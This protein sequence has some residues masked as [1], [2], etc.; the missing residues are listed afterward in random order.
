ME[1]DEQ[2]PLYEFY[3]Q[4]SAPVEL[5]KEHKDALCSPGW[6]YKPGKLELHRISCKRRLCE[7]CGQYWAYKW[8]KALEEKEKYG[9]FLRK[10]PPR[11]ALTLTTAQRVDFKTMWHCFRYFWQQIR[12]VYPKVKYF[13]TVEFNQ[14]H[15]QPHFHFIL[16]GYNFIDHEYIRACWE[17]AQVWCELENIAW[18]LR[19]ERIR[20]N[21]VAYF[22]KYITKMRGGKDEI[23]TR[24]DWQGRHI[25]YSQANSAKGVKGFFPTTV[26]CMA[27]FSKF[28]QAIEAGEQLDRVFFWVRRPVQG[29][30]AF[31]E[32]AHQEAEKLDTLVNAKWEY[33][34]DTIRA[35]PFLSLA[36]LTLTEDAPLPAKPKS[37]N[38]G[39]VRQEVKS[40]N[41]S[42]L[43]KLDKLV[44]W[45]YY[46]IRL[47][48]HNHNRAIA[49]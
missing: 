11:L 46:L 8:R 17:Q 18:V 14:K 10:K 44:N 1:T 25:R 43:R 36:Q 35:G 6:A 40:L 16:D 13:G 29:L 48:N 9:D 47:D 21:I 42:S 22:T 15:T 7:K 3:R 34:R 33:W 49:R 20:K 26:A 38:L 2:K 41:R 32:K 23:P 4:T 31:Q 30:S 27:E 39:A 5:T 12:L 24:E 37:V 19:I 45:D 28:S